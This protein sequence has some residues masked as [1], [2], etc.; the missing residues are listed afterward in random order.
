MSD[1][2]VIGII[3][4][5][6]SVAA[7]DTFKLLVDMQEAVT[8]QEYLEVVVHNNSRVP[9]RTAG[10]LGQGPSAL[11]ELRR[12]VEICNAAGAD[13]LVLACMTS[14]HFI[15]DLQPASRAVFIDGIGETVDQVVH[16]LP[17]VRRVGI[18]AST[19][20]LQCGLFQRR[21]EAAGLEPVVFDADEQQHFFM[22]PI[23]EPWGIKSGHVTG[24]PRERFKAAV[25]RLCELGADAVIG[26]CSEVQT[27]LSD[28][29]LPVPLVNSIDCLCRAAIARCL[30]GDA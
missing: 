13:F 12:S 20:N 11:P 2:K 16:E 22:D 6:G 18:L 1:K 15:P 26:G 14:H 23:Y 27:V 24:K 17:D 21:L 25:D 8:D 4:G 29:D 30:G 9:D 3:G 7:V 19:G 10:I 28:D 5:M